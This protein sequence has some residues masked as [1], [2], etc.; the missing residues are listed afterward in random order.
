MHVWSGP[1]AMRSVTIR[2]CLALAALGALLAALLRPDPLRAQR[3]P[4]QHPWGVDPSKVP[5]YEGPLDSKV[6]PAVAKAVAYLRKREDELIRGQVGEAA[7]VLQA[8]AKAGLTYEGLIQPDDPFVAALIR[9]LELACSGGQFKSGRPKFHGHDLY[10]AGCVIMAFA[11]YDVFARAN[12]REQVRV[13]V[14]HILESIKPNGMWGYGGPK[15]EQ[16]SDNSISQYALLGLW[17]ANATYGIR[18]E[19]RVFER[20]AN[21]MIQT[22]HSSGG[23]VYHPQEGGAPTLSITAGAG[24]SIGIC[25][26][27]LAYGRRRP[28][29][30]GMPL[31][32][33]EEVELEEAQ[34]AE[35]RAVAGRYTPTLSSATIEQSLARATAWLHQ[36]FHVSP[37]QWPMYYVY[38]LERFATL[39]GDNWPG[40]GRLLPG[41][42]PIDWYSLVAH[43]L[44]TKQRPN[45]S[46]PE[47]GTGASSEVGTAWGILF[48]VRSTL[49]SKHSHANPLG[50]GSLLSGRGLPRNLNDL[51]TNRGEL[52]PKPIGERGKLLAILE[53]LDVKS[54]DAALAAVEEEMTKEKPVVEDVLLERW[55]RLAERSP[56]PEV[57][58]KAMAILG[59]SGN[60]DVVPTLLRG[61]GDDNPVVVRAAREA[62]Q[63][64]SRKFF[65][66]GPRSPTPEQW[67]REVEAWYEWYRSIRPDWELEVADE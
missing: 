3:G 13:V 46:W 43:A 53:K 22:Q 21:W 41:D 57:R 4:V 47:H 10:E 27:M 8:L 9:K 20:A 39:N 12:H 26:D 19:P 42:P 5:Q 64:I 37:P 44:I 25:R 49:I 30:K 62:L 28:T 18:I 29:G 34:E 56:S 36:H 66:L 52:K 6:R 1:K 32:P 65:G 17:E 63:R 55:R 31:R 45:G 67:R 54:I 61:L 51:V 38:A 60:L 33:L 23:F 58:A 7:L 50:G 11:A 16:Q 35:R 14:N 48:L 59:R 40:N 15:N 24:G 2:V